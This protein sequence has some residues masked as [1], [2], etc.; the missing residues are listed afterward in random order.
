M[1]RRSKVKNLSGIFQNVKVEQA[2]C[3][4][5]GYFIVPVG[6]DWDVPSVRVDC[7]GCADCAGRK[8]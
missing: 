3:G 5:V 7:K 2:R 6:P 8:P 4:G 1:T